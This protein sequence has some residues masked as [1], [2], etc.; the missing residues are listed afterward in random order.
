MWRGAT[1][2]ALNKCGQARHRGGYKVN[3]VFDDAVGGAF[4]SV[5]GMGWESLK[6]GS[7]VAYFSSLKVM[8]MRGGGEYNYLH[9]ISEYPVPGGRNRR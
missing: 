2:E 6:E 9:Q 3:H 5:G 8:T 1:A 4:V 7:G